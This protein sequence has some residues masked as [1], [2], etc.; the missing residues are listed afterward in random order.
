MP[1]GTNNWDVETSTSRNLQE[2]VIKNEQ[3]IYVFLKVRSKNDLDLSFNF[4]LK[5]LKDIV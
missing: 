3:Y 4:T 2:H 1:I 5:G